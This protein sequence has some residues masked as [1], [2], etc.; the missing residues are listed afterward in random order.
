MLGSSWPLS[1]AGFGCPSAPGSLLAHSC[2]IWVVQRGFGVFEV[3]PAQPGLA[4]IP[5]MPGAGHVAFSASP[6]Q[7]SW[8][9]PEVL[10]LLL[11][12]KAM[13]TWQRDGSRPAP[14]AGIAPAALGWGRRRRRRKVLQPECLTHS[15][16]NAR[17]LQK[18]TAKPTSHS[19]VVT[20]PSLHAPHAL[21]GTVP[22]PK[23]QCLHVPPEIC[24]CWSR[25][26]LGWPRSEK[27]LLP[28]LPLR[29]CEGNSARKEE[30]QRTPRGLG[31]SRIPPR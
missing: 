1:D 6:K 3:L 9:H 15:G 13:E 19:K 26:S 12:L 22:M 8:S 25:F 16:G 24:S 27:N 7:H 5:R 2:C 18:P 31:R 14:A 23:V 11:P 20:V 30:S 29:A 4:L 28:K 17:T 21:S 10:V